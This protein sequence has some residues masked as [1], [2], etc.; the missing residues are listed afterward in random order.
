VVAEEVGE[1][2][3]PSE[4]EV[5]DMAE[6][7]RKTNISILRCYRWVPNYT[8]IHKAHCHIVATAWQL[9]CTN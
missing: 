4:V 8:H 5:L 1:V 3:A 9:T 2:I 7:L 6:Y